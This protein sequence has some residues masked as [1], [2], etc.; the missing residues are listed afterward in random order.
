MP[1]EGDSA[2]VAGVLADKVA[3]VVRENA[4]ALALADTSTTR[5]MGQLEAVVSLLC[6]TPVTA[7]TRAEGCHRRDARTHGRAPATDVK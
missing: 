5:V 7:I 6:V 3:N 4:E 2:S 1:G